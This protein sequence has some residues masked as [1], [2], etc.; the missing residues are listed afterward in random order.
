MMSGCKLKRKVF[1]SRE[2][3]FENS[4]HVK[5][6]YASVVWFTTISANLNL[7]ALFS[8]SIC[9]IIELLANKTVLRTL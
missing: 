8:F 9:G 1:I 6:N 5:K 7:L 4:L 3:A 2:T